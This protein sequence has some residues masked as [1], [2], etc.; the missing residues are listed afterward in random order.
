M[1]WA[2]KKTGVPVVRVSSETEASEFIKKHTMYA[3]GF[4]ENFEACTLNSCVMLHDSA[5]F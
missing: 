1:T 2:R 4:F 3:V 5:I